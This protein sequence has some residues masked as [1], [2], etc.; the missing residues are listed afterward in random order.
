VIK[1]GKNQREADA[2]REPN[3]AASTAIPQWLTG[4]VVL[5]K[6]L[7]VGKTFAMCG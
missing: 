4:D 6:S 1:K 7:K 5:M 3:A 2:K